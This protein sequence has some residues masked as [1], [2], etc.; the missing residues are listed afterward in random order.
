VFVQCE[1]L[2]KS[3]IIIFLQPC[4]YVEAQIITLEQGWGTCDPQAKCSPCEHLI[5][6]ASYILSPN[7]EYNIV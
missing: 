7:L 4:L 3:E 2:D 5:W 1:K 6:P